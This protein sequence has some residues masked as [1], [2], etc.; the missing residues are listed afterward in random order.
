MISVRTRA[1]TSA[2][3]S[4][5]KILTN[6]GL[7][8]NLTSDPQVV[9]YF[10]EQKVSYILHEARIITNRLYTFCTLQQLEKPVSLHS[11]HQIVETTNS[12]TTRSCTFGTRNRNRL[13]IDFSTKGASCSNRSNFGS[14]FRILSTI[15]SITM[16]L[17]RRS[18]SYV[19]FSESSQLKSALTAS[20]SNIAG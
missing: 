2:T 10:L 15:P 8:R 16:T 3:H 7:L 6:Y 11:T 9:F 13:R 17:R 4:M 5:P 14:D 19:T 20:V 1:E 18:H 12:I